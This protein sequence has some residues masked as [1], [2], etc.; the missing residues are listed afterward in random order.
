MIMQFDVCDFILF[1]YFVL[2]QFGQR[3]NLTY[4]KSSSS[5]CNETILVSIEQIS[6]T[7]LLPISKLLNYNIE[8][9]TKID[10]YRIIII[11]KILI[12]YQFGYYSKFSLSSDNFLI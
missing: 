10:Q 9:K 6:S 7:P 5:F 4:D 2:Y 8:N 3:M 12:Y 11:Y 1:L